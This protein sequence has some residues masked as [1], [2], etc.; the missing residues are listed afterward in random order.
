[1]KE[2][3]LKASI[4]IGIVVAT[5]SWLSALSF[6]WYAVAVANTMFGAIAGLVVTTLSAMVATAMV[7]GTNA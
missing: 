4:I 5:A 2:Y 1:M 6:M 3:R 7:R